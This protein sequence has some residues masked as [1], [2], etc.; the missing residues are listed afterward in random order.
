MELD[1]RS[2]LI[3]AAAGVPPDVPMAEWP[4]MHDWYEDDPDLHYP[5]LVNWIRRQY[6]GLAD[7][8]EGLTEDSFGGP[9]HEHVNSLA[10]TLRFYLDSFVRR[11]LTNQKSMRDMVE[12]EVKRLRDKVMEDMIGTVDFSHDVYHDPW[13]EVER[14]RAEAEPDMPPYVD[15]A[16]KICEEFL[17]EF[18]K[19]TEHFSAVVKPGH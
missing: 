9:A 11:G 5:G 2:W 10:H 19:M 16:V 1:F 3:E 13:E 12:W 4:I 8:L 15:Q 6:H 18:W 14:R 7:R 17:P